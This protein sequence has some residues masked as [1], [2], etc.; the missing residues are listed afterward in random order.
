MAKGMKSHNTGSVLVNDNSKCVARM[1]WGRENVRQSSSK[2]ART[3]SICRGM[4]E[5]IIR[6]NDPKPAK[7]HT[8]L[9]LLCLELGQAI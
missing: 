7:V 3:Q 4:D 5:K 9:E 1:F 2:K 6:R 8:E